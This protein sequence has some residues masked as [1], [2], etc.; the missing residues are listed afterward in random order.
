[1]S[2]PDPFS[3]LEP[4]ERQRL[5]ELGAAEMRGETTEAG[6]MMYQEFE[7]PLGVRRYSN[8][9]VLEDGRVQ[10]REYRVEVDDPGTFL[11]IEMD[12]YLLEQGI[13]DEIEWFTV[14]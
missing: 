3:E 10:V 8:V 5:F 7:T 12:R 6:W 14:E 9:R 11:D 13:I 2:E 1:M 4:G